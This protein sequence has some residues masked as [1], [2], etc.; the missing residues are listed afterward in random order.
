MNM[1]LLQTLQANGDVNAQVIHRCVDGERWVVE[2]CPSTEAT[3]SICTFDGLNAADAARYRAESQQWLTAFYE[4]QGNPPFPQEPAKPVVPADAQASCQEVPEQCGESPMALFFETPADTR[5]CAD[6][7][8]GDAYWAGY[9]ECGGRPPYAPAVLQTTECSGATICAMN[10]STLGCQAVP[11]RP[12]EAECGEGSS[13]SVCGSSNS[14]FYYRSDV[15]FVGGAMCEGKGSVCASVG[16]SPERSVTCDGE[17]VE[18]EVPF[19]QP[20]IVEVVPA[21]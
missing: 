10:E 20:T 12:G 17:R 16:E 4:T 6:P 11:C 5:E 3:M 13:Y 15:G 21:Q 2:S 8:G 9:T 19:A 14:E 18:P 7:E 1:S